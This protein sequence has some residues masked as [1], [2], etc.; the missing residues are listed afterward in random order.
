[1]PKRAPDEIASEQRLAA[2]IKLFGPTGREGGF[3]SIYGNFGRFLAEQFLLNEITP[4]GPKLAFLRRAQLKP[5][6]PHA[7]WGLGGGAPRVGP[8]SALIPPKASG[9]LMFHKKSY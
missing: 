2:A 8:S 6:E 5:V 9:S 7:T 1:M 3:L 4:R